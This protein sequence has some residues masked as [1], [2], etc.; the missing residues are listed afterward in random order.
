MIRGPYRADV[1]IVIGALFAVLSLMTSAYLFIPSHESMDAPLVE[2][3]NGLKMS[4]SGEKVK[5]LFGSDSHIGAGAAYNTSYHRFINDVNNNITPD[6]I[7]LLGDLTNGGVNWQ[8][9]A[10]KNQTDNIADAGL[11]DNNTFAILGNHDM[12]STSWRSIWN[13]WKAVLGYN[14][15][16]TVQI[17]NILFIGISTQG[18]EV[19]G[20]A[21][22]DLINWVNDTIKSNTDK[23]IILLSHHPPSNTTCRSDTEDES[24]KIADD[25]KLKGMLYWQRQNVSMWFHGHIHASD[26]IADSVVNWNGVTIAD[27]SAIECQMSPSLIESYLLNMTVGSNTATLTPRHSWA[28]SQSYY[29]VSNMHTLSLKYPFNARACNITSPTSSPTAY[30]DLATIDIDGIAYDSTRV[31]NIT[32]KNT[33]TG[34]FGA[35]SGTTIWSITGI[36]LR[37]GSNDI[38][39]TA[40][41]GVG[42]TGSD[43]IT[44]TYTPP[45]IP[46]VTGTVNATSGTAPLSISFACTPTGG[47][48]PYTFWWTFG[49]GGTS[50]S[51]NLSHT[52]TAAGTYI[53]RVMVTDSV[54][55]TGN[56]TTDISVTWP[57]QP[58]IAGALI[59]LLAITTIAAAAIAVFILIRKQKKKGT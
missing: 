52:Y 24:W 21:T 44:V 23:N 49:D 16:W 26:G 12:S 54:S 7:F 55:H 19:R 32:W 51:Q 40:Y 33:A 56:W 39:V 59:D 34:A 18:Y 58:T 11:R 42:V 31:T 22:D 8:R 30:T 36:P 48:G 41:A 2:P 46:F 10:W 6:A 15:N 53:V 47:T 35:A 14:P 29:N 43:T 57:S 45:V 4:V 17:G 1:R 3:P 5:I 38:T 20:E 9:W 27:I 13:Q 28:W 37:S 25:T 50:T